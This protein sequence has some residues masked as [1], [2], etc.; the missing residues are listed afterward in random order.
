MSI[1]GK[2]VNYGFRAIKAAPKL[3]FGTNSD[4]VGKA[5]RAAYKGSNGSVFSKLG[6]AVKSGVTVTF[7]LAIVKDGLV[8]VYQ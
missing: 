7:D 1:L 8:P 3:V 4:I 2:I 6:S 5:A